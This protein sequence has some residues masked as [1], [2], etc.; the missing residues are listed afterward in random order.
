MRHLFPGESR[1][2][3]KK[4]NLGP[5]VRRETVHCHFFTSANSGRSEAHTSELQSLMR[6]SYAVFCLKKQKH[7][8]SFRLHLSALT[9]SP[10]YSPP[11]LHFLILSSPQTLLN[12]L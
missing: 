1:G 5:G 3:A 4:K 7:F 2:P 12:T 6:I 9:P 10:S 8:P 11:L